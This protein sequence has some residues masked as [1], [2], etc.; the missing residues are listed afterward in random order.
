MVDRG[1]DFYAPQT[2][3]DQQGRRILIGWMG[4]PDAD[5]TNP[6]VKKWLAACL[7][8]PET[9][10]YKGWKAVSGAGKGIGETLPEWQN[11][12]K[13]EFQNLELPKCAKVQ[14]DFKD[15]KK[16]GIF[17]QRWSKTDLY[18]SCSDAGPG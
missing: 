12:S 5:Y 2:F 18:G 14:I 15:C 8:D 7:N 17:H 13:E 6:T 1:F 10:P 3:E 11:I 4:I 16:Y 9:A